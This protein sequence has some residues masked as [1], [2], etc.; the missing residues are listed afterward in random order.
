MKIF[1]YCLS[2][3]FV[4]ATS[5]LT[6]QPTLSV[7]DM[8]PTLGDQYDVKAY[9][10][11]NIDF[12]EGPAGANQTWDFS[13]LEPMRLFD[14][15][16][17]ILSPEE[18]VQSEDFPNADFVWFLDGLGLYSYYAINGNNIELIGSILGNAGAGNIKTTYSDTEDGL[19]FPLSFGTSYMYTSAFQTEIF[20]ISTPGSREGEVTVDGY[21]TIIT[22]IN[23]YNNVLRV[24]T[25]V[26]D[27]LGFTETQYAWFRAGQ[28]VPVAVYSDSD[29]PDGSEEIYF[30]ELTSTI[31]S[32]SNLD[33]VDFGVQI[34]GN[35]VST[36]LELIGTEQL[37]KHTQATLVTANGQIVPCSWNNGGIV[38]IP[39]GLTGLCYLWLKN[40]Q[41]Q[42]ALPFVV[43]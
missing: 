30:A 17:Q 39:Q 36:Q 34:A 25:V 42:Q 40:E 27:Q 28:F 20:N 38:T 21:G 43:R 23:T 15:T 32:I 5:T 14:L 8:T 35:I 37:P 22:P 2:F 12:S 13:Q 26:L 9:D 19:Q 3:L 31:N 7:G 6:A 16:F 33:Q 4:A 11:T 29:N 24:K 41:G 10:S 18:G 1:F